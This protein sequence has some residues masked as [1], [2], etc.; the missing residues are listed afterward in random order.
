MANN[1]NL[2][3]PV[4]YSA[5]K[6]VSAEPFGIIDS[7]A[8]TFDDK[9]V[10]IG[11]TIKVPVAP[12]R[13]ATTYTPAM[14]TTAGTDA[15]A[16]SVSV[17]ITAN[18]MVSWN[19]TG[20]EERSLMNGESANTWFEQLLMQGM[21]ELRNRAEGYA[22]SAAVVGASRA[23]G[24]AGT[25]PFAS[26]LT[27]LTNARK[28]LQ[29]NGAPLVDLQFVGD[30]NA[31][32][33]LRNLGVLQN[34]YQAGS[35]Q[36]RRSGNFLPQIGFNIKESAAVT[37]RA[38][39]TGTSYTTTAAGF[40]VGTTSIPLITGSGTVLA[41]DVVTFAGDT[42]K[43]VVATGIAAP[44]TIV[45]AAPGLRVAMSAATKA[46]TIGAAYTGN[47]AMERSAVVGIMRPPLIPANPTI[48]QL[49]VTDS[50]GMTYLLC[51][52]VGDG[53]RT[54]RLHL[55]SGFKSVNSEFSAIV[56]G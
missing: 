30:T 34:A 40:A 28:I 54:I 10:A 17:S 31:G 14:T 18:D 22:W 2:L 15:T 32:L 5:A 37:S 35:E 23:F 52:V 39:G 1:L 29:D 21:R 24:T 43:Y 3:A 19:I 38:A 11:D 55:A 53:M 7:I 25:T 6:K 45:L 48:S 26:D 44:G 9:G 8:A 50:F 41:G 20:E 16:T 46:M 49:P 13:S 51:D 4:A 12:V 56:L 33:A 42:N 47:I 27:A 36:E